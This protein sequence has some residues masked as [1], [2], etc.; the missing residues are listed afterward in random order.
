MTIEQALKAL[1]WE[2][3]AVEKELRYLIEA[4]GD[5]TLRAADGD[6][7][8]E[9]GAERGDDGRWHLAIDAHIWIDVTGDSFR[10]HVTRSVWSVDA[11]ADPVK[12]LLDGIADIVE[13]ILGEFHPQAVDAW[14]MEQKA[15]IEAEA[16]TR[17][18]LGQWL[19]QNLEE[20]QKEE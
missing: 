11:D 18:R 12:A 10:K 2:H 1:G 15:A 14:E 19:Q 9:V 8:L 16:Q 7:V 5:V 13:E 4:G 3:S 20:A 6:L 17:E